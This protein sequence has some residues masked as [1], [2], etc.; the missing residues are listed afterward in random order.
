MEYPPGSYDDG[1]FRVSLTGY[2]D[3]ISLYLRSLELQENYG[4]LYGLAKEYQYR[5]QY[6][7]AKEYWLRAKAVAETDR[8]PASIEDPSF[9]DSLRIPSSK[10]VKLRE[11][12]KICE[13]N[14][15][16]VEKKLN[17]AVRFVF[18]GSYA[19]GMNASLLVE[20]PNPGEIEFTARR[21]DLAP[22][23]A[24]T[25]YNFSNG[26]PREENG[27]KLVPPKW[28]R[29]FAQ[30]VSHSVASD[31]ARFAAEPPIT[32]SA[33]FEP[34][35]T[36]KRLVPPISEPGAY[37]LTMSAA[38]GAAALLF[39]TENV[40]YSALELPPG[41]PVNG[42]KT[43]NYYFI[44]S[45]TGERRSDLEL[46]VFTLNRV[47]EFNVS[48][49][50]K[51]DADGKIAKSEFDENGFSIASTY[52]LDEAKADIAIDVF[53][54][55]NIRELVEAPMAKPGV[56]NA[57]PGDQLTFTVDCEDLGMG[58]LTIY[59]SEQADTL[60][61]L[62]ALAEKLN[63]PVGDVIVEASSN[64]A[65]LPVVSVNEP[66]QEGKKGGIAFH[67]SHADYLADL[68]LETDGSSNEIDAPAFT[69]LPASEY[70]APILFDHY[71]AF[72]PNGWQTAFHI[73][74]PDKP[75]KFTLTAP[76]TPG[77]YKAAFLGQSLRAT[78]AEMEFVVEEKPEE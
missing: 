37:L 65:F 42:R 40:V 61:A 28:T 60:N 48:R 71:Q 68:P 19:Y 64:Q 53:D 44:D 31:Q 38:P 69:R 8:Y 73:R 5:G 36:R 39:L 7:K 72:L 75:F 26:M 41:A 24:K 34:G 57:R 17:A 1:Y 27:K 45:R 15:E 20:S 2:A 33:V 30:S 21:L 51:T 77:T 23:L 67:A 56:K 32:W 3:F 46:D 18:P 16:E 13:K 59:P 11:R 54:R 76:Q 63:I 10:S 62:A 49:K 6:A 58:F 25:R 9:N 50:L 66:V 70:N 47:R 12:L 14:L 22:E 29:N 35:E 4:A 55:R 52:A 78:Y 43:R 74:K